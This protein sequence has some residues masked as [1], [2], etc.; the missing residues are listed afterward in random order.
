MAGLIKRDVKLSERMWLW[1]VLAILTSLVMLFAVALGVAG[2]LTNLDPYWFSANMRGYTAIG[3]GLGGTAVFFT[4]LSYAFSARKRKLQE[5]W[6]IGRGTMMAWLWVHV[7]AGLL[8]L[9]AATLHAGYGLLSV[10]F[11]SGKL[12]YWAF[13]FLILSGLAWRIVYW[14]VPGV[15]A[16]RVGN[17]SEAGSRKRIEDLTTEI[18]KLSAG[19]SAQLHQIKDWLLA[20]RRN[21]AEIA[22]A[23]V[24]PDEQQLLPEIAR[25]A[26]RR[27]AAGERIGAQ[28]RFVSILQRWRVVHV[29]LSLFVVVMLVVHVIGALDVPQAVLPRGSSYDGAFAAFPPAENCKDCH[30]TIYNQWKA[31]IHAHAMTGPLMV[32]Q[33]N[34]DLRTSLANVPP[35]IK[36]FCINCHGPVDALHDLTD[37]SLPMPGGALGNQGVTCTVC[38]Q[39]TKEPQAGTAGQ[40]S[41]FQQLLSAG[42]TFYGP[43]PD[44]VGNAYH[45]SRSTP[46]Y[47]HPENICIGCHNV[48]FDRNADGNIQKGVDLVLQTTNDEFA[49]YQARGGQSTC[50]TCHMPASTGRAADHADIPLQ[51]DY[52]APARTI[53]DHGFVGVDAALDDPTDPQRAQRDAFIRFA[54]S[55]SFDPSG[56]QIDGNKLAF[57]VQIANQTGHN[58][59]TGFAFA[60]QLWL[61]IAVKDRSGE[62]VFSSGVLAK[63]SSDLCIDSTFGE[64]DNPFKSIMVGCT[65]VDPNL[66]LLQ[67]KLVDKI[68]VAGD[69]SGTPLKDEHGELVV[70]QSKTGKETTEQYI[71]GGGVVR[72]RAIDKSSMAPLRPSETRGYAYSAPLNTAHGGISSSGTVSVRL[73]FRNLPPYFLRGLGSHQPAGDQPKIAPFVDKLRVVEIAKL[74][75]KYGR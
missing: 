12:L 16:P 39:F 68:S 20:A 66:V 70:I 62:V 61:E 3:L 45:K 58:L 43:I 15:A 75:A 28:H 64:S 48:T 18:E 32:V 63:P 72:K 57:K 35:D 37:Q 73:L 10:D 7:F 36:R 21:P 25:L 11:S 60:R 5:S 23:Q 41:T 1:L 19:R 6:K 67:L 55:I 74:E 44:A 56:I 4:F 53:H 9:V 49:E 14:I 2:T 29:P 17:Y 52:S 8:A 40:A 31:S 50:V 24:P 33:N 59:P 65:D 54:A 51:Q 13:F 69:A 30:L 47:D 38:H 26:D 27:H 22:R 71:E 46:V 42:R 34:A